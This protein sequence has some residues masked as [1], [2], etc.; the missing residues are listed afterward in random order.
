MLSG[1]LTVYGLAYIEGKA[2]GMRK[3]EKMT[4]II[5]N[6]RDNSLLRHSF[7]ALAEETFGLDFEA[8]YQNGF[9]GDDYN[10]Y[11]IVKDGQVVAN[12]SV[13]RTDFLYDGRIRHFLQLGTVMT[14]E[15]YRRRGCIRAIMEQI[16]ADYNGKTDGIY[17]F[18][19]DSVLDFYP[20]FG[21]RKSKEYQYSI[22]LRNTGAC[23]YRHIAMDE[24]AAWQR[25]RRTMKHNVCHGRL[26]MTGNIGL[27]FFYLTGFMQGSVYCHA[28][29]STY[30]VA[31]RQG[32]ELFLHHVFS[33]TLTKLTE[34]LDLFGEEVR[35]VTLGFTPVHNPGD[36]AAELQEEDCTLFIKGRDLE[37]IEREKLRIPTL[38]HA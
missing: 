18:A 12:V 11:S 5:K 14:K 10:P 35:Q 1:K 8:W 20:R 33:D 22:Q 37:I 7:N 19:N 31:D 36:Q 24:P 34:V 30:V 32:T 17:L 28:P 21:F 3:E 4:E 2:S 16:E 26:D 6:Y 38:A 9:W 29:S 27:P 13:N 23:E 25:L 15:A